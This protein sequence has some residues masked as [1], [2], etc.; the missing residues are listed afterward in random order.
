MADFLEVLSTRVTTGQAPRRRLLQAGGIAGALLAMG[1]PVVALA[2]Q[3]NQGD[4]GDQGGNKGGDAKGGKIRH[5]QFPV[6]GSATNGSASF[7]GL[8]QFTNFA[9]QPAGTTNQLVASGLLSGVFT[10]KNGATIATLKNAPYTG[11]VTNVD[12]PPSCQVLTLTLGPLHLD[13]LGLVVTI[14]NPIILDITAV[15]GAG[16]LL[17][18]LLCAVV[19][20]LNPG[21]L[22]GLLGNLS[23]LVTALNNLFTTLNG[24]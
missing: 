7:S 14:P 23:G 6:T 4:Q 19:N 1:M 10:D 13:L 17:G 11:Q 8:L 9:S 21:G 16:N 20:L 22:S 24:L 18:N 2:D 15:P 3:N 12:P 5:G